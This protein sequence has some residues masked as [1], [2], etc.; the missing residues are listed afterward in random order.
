[1]EILDKI[2]SGGNLITINDELYFLKYPGALDRNAGQL[3]YEKELAF[4]KTRGRKTRKELESTAIKLGAWKPEFYEAKKFFAEEKSRLQ[5]EKEQLE[6]ANKG[7]QTPSSKLV[8]CCNNL[9]F[10]ENKIRHYNSL[11][12]KYIEV[13]SAEY[14]AEKERAIYIIYTSAHHFPSMKRVWCAYD[15]ILN[16][17][18]R[19]LVI[20]MINEFFK[21][22]PLGQAIIRQIA[23]SSMWRSRWNFSKSSESL[24]LRSA[25]DLT[26]DQYHLIYWSQIYD[27]AYES[28]EPPGDDIV[29]D[30]KK[31]DEWLEEQAKKRQ[32]KQ[33]HK[34]FEQ[35]LSDKAKNADEVGVVVQGYYVKDCI[36]NMSKEDKKLLKRHNS[37]CNYGKFVYYNDNERQ[38]LI[39]KVQE[40]NP[41]H[42]RS[43]LAQEHNK[44]AKHDG[45]IDEQ[46]LR[47][48]NKRTLMGFNKK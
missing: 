35:K 10:V 38:K 14:S 34:S 13:P 2:V 40:S 29:E 7:R 4:Q 25:A 23:R 11:F 39:N 20:E 28:M 3:I 43:I 45:M 22:D 15:E 9:I 37:E 27:A 16:D 30:D 24:F 48:G 36:C 17:E 31:F 41:A 5:K 18:N 8:K 46:V 42:V 6:L 12:N 33:S 26:I 21:I 44:L 32:Q 47:K 19:N 1:M